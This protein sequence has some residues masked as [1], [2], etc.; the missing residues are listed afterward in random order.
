M[1][2]ATNDDPLDFLSNS[3]QS[4]ATRTQA[5][6]IQLLLYE[7]IR[8]KDLI[9]YYEAIPNGAGQLGASILNELVS[10]AYQSLVNYDTEL[11]RKYYDL[12]QNCD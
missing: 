11:M 10:E 5:D 1:T 7:I 4:T 9:K 2:S 12:L 6:L 3:L 8:V